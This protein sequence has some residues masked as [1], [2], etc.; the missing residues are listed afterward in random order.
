[1][2]TSVSLLCRCWWCWVSLSWI[3]CRDDPRRSR[4][5]PGAQWRGEEETQVRDQLEALRTADR[6]S[7]RCAG[8]TAAAA[9]CWMVRISEQSILPLKSHTE[10]DDS[11]FWSLSDTYWSHF[12]LHC[13]FYVFWCCEM[14]NCCCLFVDFVQIQLNFLNFLTRR[15]LFCCF[16]SDPRPSG[17]RFYDKN[18]RWNFLTSWIV[19]F[20][21]SVLICR[22]KQSF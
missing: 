20:V 4:D 2:V 3:S 10:N 14:L 11:L 21:I 9:S 1:M 19:A 15:D 18:Q 6:S 17:K 12:D 8:E 7:L 16:A 13:I 5:V 22:E